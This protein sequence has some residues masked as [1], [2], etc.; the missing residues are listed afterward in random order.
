MKKF[1]VQ[2]SG[3]IG[4]Q[5]FQYACAR[6]LAL[7]HNRELII[8]NWSGFIRD[9]QY[10]R[11]Y[12]L[13]GFKIE[14]RF[15]LP[16]ERIPLWTYRILKKIF[17]NR[18]KLINRNS[19]GDFI[20]ETESKFLPEIFDIKITNNTWLIGY[21][22]S[23][24]YFE[25]FK[26][27]IFNDFIPMPPAS[28]KEIYHQLAKI[29]SNC[30]SIAVGVRFYEESD[31]P[32]AHARNGL[33]KSISDIAAALT[34]LLKKRPK[35]KIFIFSTKL[36]PELEKLKIA[37]DTFFVTSENGY[38]GT[39]ETLWLLSLCKHHVFNNSSF[40]WWGA[41]ISMNLHRS[42]DQIILASNNFFNKDSLCKTWNEF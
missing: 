22:Q 32:S 5:M 31:D 42:K 41:W 15:A 7:R 38:D 24:L 21:W 17:K 20:I 27:I 36:F 8:D 25:E 12:Q 33:L 37:E 6:A 13:D 2:L 26:E 40:F 23:P 11:K 1:F 9:K 4:N 18:S 10:R 3:G 14:S 39:M 35:A 29:I 30:D 19:Y 28:Q 34:E 16:H